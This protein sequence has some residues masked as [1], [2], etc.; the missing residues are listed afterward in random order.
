[1]RLAIDT[2]GIDRLVFGTDW[3][4]W[5][6]EAHQLAGDFLLQAGLSDADRAKIDTGNAK[7]IFGG[8][9]PL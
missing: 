9:F 1:L 2:Y 8:K 6:G 3:P 5:K 4:F 7:E